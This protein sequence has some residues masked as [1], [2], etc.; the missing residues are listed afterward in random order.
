MRLYGKHSTVGLRIVG[1]CRRLSYRLLSQLLLLNHKRSSRRAYSHSKTIKALKAPVAL[2]TDQSCLGNEEQYIQAQKITYAQKKNHLS[3]PITLP[4]FYN[5]YVG[6][7]PHLL[8]L[9]VPLVGLDTLS[10]RTSRRARVPLTTT[11]SVK[12]NA[13]AAATTVAADISRR[14]KIGSIDGVLVGGNL[15]RRRNGWV[16]K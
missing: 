11:L 5:A 3:N 1:V 12:L 16:G 10:A 9:R 13:T 8:T 4:K 2:I 14:G 15:G 7:T 6:Y